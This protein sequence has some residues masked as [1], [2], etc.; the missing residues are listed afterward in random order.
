ML[1]GALDMDGRMAGDSWLEND[2]Q[3]TSTSGASPDS[4][5]LR[6]PRLWGTALLPYE[7]Q[8]RRGVIAACR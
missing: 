7:Q 6:I 1:S 5:T 3:Y 4:R 2:G 8:T